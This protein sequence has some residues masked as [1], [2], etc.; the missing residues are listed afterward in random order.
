MTMELGSLTSRKVEK[1]EL[2]SFLL[3][4]YKSDTETCENYTVISPAAP[5]VIVDFILSKCVQDSDKFLVSWEGEDI[6]Y[7]GIQKLPEVN[8]LSGFS[9]HPFYRDQPELKRLWWEHVEVSAKPYITG[10]Y[11]SNKPAY[12]FLIK[13]CVFEKYGIDESDEGRKSPYL[14]FKSK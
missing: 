4:L 11:V 5:D 3:E 2:A 1:E 8:F 13:N 10:V 12:K 7:Y 14:I 6:G 9:L